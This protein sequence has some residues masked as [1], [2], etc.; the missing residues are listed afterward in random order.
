M[1]LISQSLQNIY[2]SV[3]I[4]EECTIDGTETEK[5]EQYAKKRRTRAC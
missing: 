2:D 4:G 1:N 3:Q 5:N